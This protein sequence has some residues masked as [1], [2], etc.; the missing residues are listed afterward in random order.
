MNS[1][2]GLFHHW[3]RQVVAM[4]NTQIL[5]QTTMEFQNVEKQMLTLESNMKQY[6]QEISAYDKKTQSLTKALL[7][8]TEE[9]SK[10][11]MV[12]F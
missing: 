12:I 11:R 5:A 10:L 2:R 6:H 8:K 4:K 3:Q 9:Q 1:T 7:E